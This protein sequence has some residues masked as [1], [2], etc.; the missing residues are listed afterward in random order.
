MSSLAPQLATPLNLATVHRYIND[1]NYVMEQKL[2]GH[3]VVV[4]GGAGPDGEVGAT[5]RNG[6][7]YT[8]G[9]PPDLAALKAP[10]TLILDGELLG[11][12]YYV[13]DILSAPGLGDLRG[14]RLRDRRVVLEQV[15]GPFNALRDLTGTSP[16]SVVP[17]ARTKQ[18]KQALYDRAIAQNLEGV[19]IKHRDSKY[20]PG[21][22]HPE[23]LKAK[24]VVT[25]DVVV[26][27]VRAD[28][29][30]SATLFAMSGG[31]LVEVGKCSLIGKPAVKVG[32][33]VEVRY[34]YFAA[35]KRLYQP[36]MVRVRSD[37]TATECD[38][39]QMK[40]VN[41]EVLVS[42]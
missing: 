1:D 40:D 8:R 42:L 34:L 25:A 9:L 21:L 32:D 39:A 2:D 37:K 41:K 23:W 13:F 22:R 29:K 27:A 4:R 33:V 24:L 15:M 26:G 31:V 36:T 5:T 16:L 10:E 12:N 38:I 7:S 6:T 30:E 19:V 17:Q 3:R 28:G 20:V 35:N 18:E 14:Q 11:L